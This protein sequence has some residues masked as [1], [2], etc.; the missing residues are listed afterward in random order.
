MMPGMIMLWYGPIAD[1]PSGWALCDGNNNT[2]DLRDKFVIC[3]KEDDSGVAKTNVHGYLEQTGGQNFHVHDVLGDGHAHDL[4]AG[5]EFVDASPAGDH[6]HHTSTSV[7]TGTADN[8]WN[9]PVFY[10]LAYIMKLPI[11]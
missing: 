2:P 3:A 1:I 8:R 9:I 5:N 7:I 10:A 4:S 11:P 6:A